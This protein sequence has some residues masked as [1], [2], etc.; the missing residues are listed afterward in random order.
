MQ[1]SLV[2]VNSTPLKY[3][4]LSRISA[5][6][7]LGAMNIGAM[8]LKVHALKRYNSSNADLVK[9]FHSLRS[10]RYKHV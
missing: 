5:V 6:N 3:E 9:R 4:P 1:Q 10:R 7:K 2:W 8:R